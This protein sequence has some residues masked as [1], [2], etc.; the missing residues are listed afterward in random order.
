MKSQ[1]KTENSKSKINGAKMK[2]LYK[3]H[4]FNIIVIF[5]FLSWNVLF[6]QPQNSTAESNVEKT[7]DKLLNPM[8]DLW[9]LQFQNNSVFLDGTITEGLREANI[10]LFQPVTP[11]PLG[12]DWNLVNRTIFQYVSTEIPTFSPLQRKLE[13]NNESGLGDTKILQLVAP[14]TQKGSFFGVGWNWTL[15]TASD[16]TLGEDSWQVG[17]AL[18]YGTVGEKL[19][20]GLLLQHAWSLSADEGSEISKSSLQYFIQYRI[21][22]TFNLGMSPLIVAD[23][24]ADSEDRWQVPIGFGFSTLVFFGKLPIKLGFEMQH[25]FDR[26]ESYGS[27]WAFQ[28]N[29]TPV[30]PNLFKDIDI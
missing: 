28:L 9:T 23:W 1:N 17:P 4:K 3:S 18:A 12:N 21:S 16:K 11:I 27:K 15:P 7:S 26:P 10:I 29:I 5:S 20:G 19:A 25:Y 24:N 30:I 13:W 6:S 8:S 22:R 2:I 14:N